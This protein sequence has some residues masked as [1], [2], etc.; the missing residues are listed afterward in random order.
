MQW[1]ILDFGQ[2]KISK[3]RMIILRLRQIDKAQTIKLQWPD[4]VCMDTVK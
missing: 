4:G 1:G 2:L 3:L